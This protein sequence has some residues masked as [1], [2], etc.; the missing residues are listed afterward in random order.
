MHDTTIG[1]VREKLVVGLIALL[2]GLAV[3]AALGLAWSFKN[4]VEISQRLRHPFQA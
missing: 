4:V 1:M 3:Y 2:V